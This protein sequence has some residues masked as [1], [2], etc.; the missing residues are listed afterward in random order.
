MGEPAIP[1]ILPTPWAG[2]DAYLPFKVK[3]DPYLASF[4]KHNWVYLLATV[5]IPAWTS[6]QGFLLTEGNSNVDLIGWTA[7]Q[8][9]ASATDAYLSASA[10]IAFTDGGTTIYRLDTVRGS[11]LSDTAAV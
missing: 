10:N 1:D 4:T 8:Y 6:F 5:R 9:N 11:P 2:L 3:K 7:S